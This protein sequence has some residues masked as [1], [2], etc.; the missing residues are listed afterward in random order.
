VVFF[1]MDTFWGRI[2]V[3]V[4][5]IGI[6]VWDAGLARAMFGGGEQKNLVNVFGRAGRTGRICMF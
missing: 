5:G 3:S 1:A 2:L 6:W 4:R